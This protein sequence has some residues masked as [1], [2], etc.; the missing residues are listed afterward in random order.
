MPD[1]SDRLSTVGRLAGISFF[2][3][4]VRA[5][6]NETPSVS[7]PIATIRR[8]LIDSERRKT[9]RDASDMVALVD[10][11]HPAVRVVRALLVR[12]LA[13]GVLPSVVVLPLDAIEAEFDTVYCDVV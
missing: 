11:D 3:A 5:L 10:A 13:P 8:Q 12:Y 4:C 9:S 7:A 1:P 6:G 2:A